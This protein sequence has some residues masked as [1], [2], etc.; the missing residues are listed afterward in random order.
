MQ[1]KTNIPI[2]DFEVMN[3]SIKHKNHFHKLNPEMP[4][5]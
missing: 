4:N 1:K 2:E 3:C 5:D